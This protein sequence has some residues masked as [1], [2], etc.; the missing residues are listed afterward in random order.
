MRVKRTGDPGPVGLMRPARNN[1]AC[2]HPDGCPRPAKALGWCDMHYNRVQKTGDPGPVG[3]LRIIGDDRARFESYADR[4]GGPEACHPW[5]GT[6]HQGYGHIY[7]APAVRGAHIIA[8]E[9]ANG[10]PVP[11]GHEIDHECHNAA[12]RAGACAPGVCEHRRCVNE[13]HLVARTK[14]EHLSVTE[15]TPPGTRGSRI[16]TAKLT[17]ALIPEIRTAIAAGESDASI[18]RRYGVIDGTI[19][20]IR[21]GKTWRHVA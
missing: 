15:W 11:P 21:I 10:I 19:R 8:W 3:S 2:R 17:E 18:G 14:G 20:H 6:L 12:L 16:N 9:W 5:T 1:G 7:I 13:R 4:S